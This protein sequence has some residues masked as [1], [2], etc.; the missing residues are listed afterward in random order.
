MNVVLEKNG[1]QEKTAESMTI[2]I[3][4]G[5]NAEAGKIEDLEKI[6]ENLINN[7]KKRLSFLLLGYL[8]TQQI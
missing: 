5:L 4:R 1:D 3:I 6:E 7:I 8:H 2:P